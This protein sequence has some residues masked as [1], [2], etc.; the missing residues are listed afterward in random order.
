[1]NSQVQSVCLWCCVPP[2]FV[3]QIN[4]LFSS[5]LFSAVI[6]RRRGKKLIIKTIKYKLDRSNLFYPE[7]IQK[8]L[9]KTIDFVENL[10]MTQIAWGGGQGVCNDAK[11]TKIHM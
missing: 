3:V 1:M 2:D 7:D 6:H 11:P 9:W 10:E 5:V 8:C 4:K